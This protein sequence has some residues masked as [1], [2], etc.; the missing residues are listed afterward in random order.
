[1]TKSSNFLKRFH[2][3]LDCLNFRM[4]QYYR[5]EIRDKVSNIV[6]QRLAKYISTFLLH[7]NH[8]FGNRCTLVSVRE[9]TVC[10]KGKK[11]GFKIVIC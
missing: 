2:R 10:E 6:S 9:M 4:Q 11:V 5:F 3:E 7:L 8:N 1:M